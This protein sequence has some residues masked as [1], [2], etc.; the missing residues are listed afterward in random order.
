MLKLLAFL[1]HCTS[2]VEYLWWWLKPGATPHLDGPIAAWWIP[3][4]WSSN[5]DWYNEQLVSKRFNRGLRPVVGNPAFPIQIGITVRLL[6]PTEWGFPK[7]RSREAYQ[8]DEIT[9]EIEGRFCERN[10]S[11]FAGVRTARGAREFVLYS[12]NEAAA[13]EKCRE[14]AKDITHHDIQFVLNRDPEW[15]V[16]KSFTAK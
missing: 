15:N 7:P 12:S 8:L 2:G 14:L 11:L 9:K 5:V 1:S 10:E 4:A 6:D 3:P 16:F 13:V